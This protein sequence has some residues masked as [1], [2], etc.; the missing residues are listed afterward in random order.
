VLHDGI[1]SLHE[2]VSILPISGR[3]C[4]VLPIA[5]Y[6]LI[7]CFVCIN[8]ASYQRSVVITPLQHSELVAHALFFSSEDTLEMCNFQPLSTFHAAAQTW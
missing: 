4:H 7:C 5:V 8:H 1:D 3:F 2:R 6:L